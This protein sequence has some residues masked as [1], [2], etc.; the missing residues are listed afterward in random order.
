VGSPSLELVRDADP[1]SPGHAAPRPAAGRPA[2]GRVAGAAAQRQR[3]VEGA[4]RC[5]AGQGL[6]K[7]T[8]D[9]VAR[10]AGYSRATLYRAFPGGKDAVM[11]AV[12]D[13]EVSRLFSAVA[14]RMGEAAD[15]EDALIEGMVTASATIAG[16]DALRY[17]LEHEP[18]VV[19]T[20]LTFEHHDEVLATVA[21]FVA[22][23][24]G[25]WLGHAEAVRVAEWAARLV[26][27][28]VACP[29]AAIDLTDPSCA[30]RVVR[31]YVLPGIAVLSAEA[32][33][34]APSG[35]AAP[36]THHRPVP[37]RELTTASKGEAS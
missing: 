35:S 22:P 21:A 25:R 13:T 26:F 19:L 17:L 1:V 16:H 11:A 23:L 18:E 29:S 34:R 5:I 20:R 31:S 8:L 14:V 36:V 15:L 32:D 3:I 6:A 12:A 7:T 37:V 33:A 2:A 9:D 10:A 24:L 30:R 28:Y 4:V 27:S